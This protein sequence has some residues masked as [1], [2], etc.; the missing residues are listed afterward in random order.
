MS[1]VTLIYGTEEPGQ[2]GQQNGLADLW[3]GRNGTAGQITER[4][5][6]HTVHHVERHADLWGTGRDGTGQI[7]EWAAHHSVHHVERHADLWD[8]TGQGS[9]QDRATAG[10]DKCVHVTRYASQQISHESTKR[11]KSVL[12]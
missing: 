8:G 2:V 1:S 4:A 7:T 9:Q 11:D 12:L 3:T 5:A 6:H 10:Q